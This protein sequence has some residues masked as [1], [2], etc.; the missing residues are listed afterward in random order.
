MQYGALNSDDVIVLERVLFCFTARRLRFLE[1][2]VYDGQTARGIRDYCSENGISLEY[3]GLDN[4]NQNDGTLPFEGARMIKGDSAESFHLVPAQFDVVLSDGCHCV[5]HVILET[6]HYGNKVVSGG[7]MLFHDTSPR[8][9]HT[10]KDPHGPNIP[11][12]HN[13]VNL[14]HALLRFPFPPWKETDR[15]W[16][17]ASPWGGMAAFQK[18]Q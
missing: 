6:I 10:M 13:S 17:D 5:N 7:F 16:N 2:G 12:F 3:C 14:A 15:R 18:I 9:Q 1:I 4:G 11:E 8:I